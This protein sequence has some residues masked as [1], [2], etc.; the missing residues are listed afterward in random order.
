MRHK[1]KTKVTGKGNANAVRRNKLES[2][3]IIKEYAGWIDEL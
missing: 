1:S 2:K 3:N